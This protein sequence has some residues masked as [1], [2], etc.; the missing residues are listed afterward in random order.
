VSQPGDEGASPNA[1]I[2][3][4]PTRKH[5]A[6]EEPPVRPSALSLDKIA[7]FPDDGPLSSTLRAIDHYLGVV[8]QGFIVF[9]LA[10][11]VA[12]AAFAAVYNKLAIRFSFEQ[13]GRWWHYIV[14]GGTFTIAMFA[15]AFATQQ[16]RLLAMD[17]VSRKL[18]PRGRL[19]LGIALRVLTVFIAFLLF[20]SGLAQRKVAGGSE[21][22]PI[23]LPFAN[24][25]FYINDADIVTSIS[26][27][28]ALIIVHSLLHIGID[29]DYL[30][31][32]KLPPE[33]ARSGH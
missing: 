18:S 2:D 22:L 15:A 20:D 33:R 32:G 3:V 10:L 16:Q 14:R 21:H 25:M 4:P 5:G 27:G 31:R 13:L 23:G 8:E 17:L 9:L 11:V 7:V 1:P 26:I 30:I 19:I 6:P 29:V 24:P 12:V 28:A